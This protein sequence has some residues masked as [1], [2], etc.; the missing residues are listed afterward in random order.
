M[1]LLDGELE[2]VGVWG[3]LFF[4]IVVMVGTRW[5]AGRKAEMSAGVRSQKEPLQG[6]DHRGNLYLALSSE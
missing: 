3:Y 4:R 2:R 5:G 6:S 1:R